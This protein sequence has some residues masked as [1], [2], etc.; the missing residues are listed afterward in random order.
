MKEGDTRERADLRGAILR[1]LRMPQANFQ[2]IGGINVLNIF[3]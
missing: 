3:Y 2:V 1:L